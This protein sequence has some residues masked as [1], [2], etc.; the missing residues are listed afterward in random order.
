M[1]VESNLL[2]KRTTS[3][4][5]DLVFQKVKVGKSRRRLLEPLPPSVPVEGPSVPAAVFHR[6]TNS[7]FGAVLRAREPTA[8]QQG[9]RGVANATLKSTF[10]TTL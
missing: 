8:W 4:D 5:I 6:A 7:G 1:A 2:D 3:N 9:L 10:G